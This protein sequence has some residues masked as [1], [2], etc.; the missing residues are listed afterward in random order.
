[1]DF[2]V[3]TGKVDEYFGYA[4]GR[5]PYRSLR[6]EHERSAVRLPFAQINQCNG[7]PFTRMYD[8]RWLIGQGVADE[9]T[10]PVL[11][12]NLTGAGLVTSP[13]TIQE[14]ILTREYPLVHDRT[15][16]PYYPMSF[17]EGMAL[18]QQYKSLAEPEKRTLF[19]GRLATYS[20]LDMWMAV[21]Q[22]MMKL[23]GIA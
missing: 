3:Y 15:N 12:G 19:I 4:Y 2:V 17:G 6:F 7:L 5:L 13:S 8:H 1:M 14:T 22:A 21:A 18:Y 16:E 11:D 23:R 20:Y 9:V 10:R